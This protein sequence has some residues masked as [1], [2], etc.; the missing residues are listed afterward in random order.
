MLQYDR[1]YTTSTQ[2]VLDQGPD[3]GFDHS[4]G[5]GGE[6]DLLH[7]SILGKNSRATMSSYH[8]ENGTYRPSMTQE[9]HGQTHAHP[10]S[11][12]APMP[13]SSLSS[14]ENIEPPLSSVHFQTP[15][16][17][18][19][20][21]VMRQQEWHADND[22]ASALVGSLKIDDAGVGELNHDYM[23][24]RYADTFSYPSWLYIGP[25]SK[26]RRNTRLRALE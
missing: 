19:P 2:V 1:D 17:H 6:E 7:Q 9:H 26:A 13:Y 11:Q 12:L 3:G 25:G 8:R 15:V 4:N 5:G 24:V 22:Y 10:H 20:V 23:R 16:Y 21:Q 14:A 18:T